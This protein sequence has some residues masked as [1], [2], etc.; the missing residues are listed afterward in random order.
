MRSGTRILLTGVTGFIGSHLARR[1]ID[2]GYTVVGLVRAGSRHDR[3]AAFADK[4]ELI[5]GNIADSRT[6]RDLIRSASAEV[7]FHLGWY[8]EAGRWH[9][10]SDHI[11]CLAASLALLRSLDGSTCRRVIV[12]GTSVEYDTDAGYVS[13]TSPIRPRS[14]YGACKAAL[15]SVGQQL[16]RQQ[17]WSYVHAR[18]FNVYGPSEDRRRLVPHV[19]HSLLQGEPCELTAGDQVR[20]YLHVDDVASAMVAIAASEL[21]GPVNVGSANPVTVSALATMIAGLVGTPE[22]LR[23]G[24]LPTSPDDY[25]ILCADN[26]LLR[27]RTGWQPRY[28]LDSGLRA[29]L[30]WWKDSLRKGRT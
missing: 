25:R 20:D 23:L 15:G 5:T 3:L 19:I 6:A 12:A 30:D 1:L 10:A 27:S 18:I 17:G 26:T 13:E 22:L 11:E 2:E 28:T 16:A 4:M 9:G 24:A 21:E 7:L 8:A 29:T 14:L